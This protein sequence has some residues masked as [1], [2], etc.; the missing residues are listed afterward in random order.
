MINDYTFSNE[1]KKFLKLHP[2]AAKYLG[3]PYYSPSGEAFYPV[4][5]TDFFMRYFISTSR[6]IFDIVE[7]QFKKF[8]ITDRVTL[9]ST[10]TNAPKIVH[11]GDLY[12]DTFYRFHMGSSEDKNNR[13]STDKMTHH[14]LDHKPT[15]SRVL[16]EGVLF[17][18]IKYPA[19]SVFF[20][21]FVTRDH[22]RLFVSEDGAIY[23]VTKNKFRQILLNEHGMPYIKS[24][25][26]VQLPIPVAIAFTWFDKEL[27]YNEYKC[28]TTS[29]AMIF[30][31]VN[32]IIFSKPKMPQVPIES[33]LIIQRIHG[34]DPIDISKLSPEFLKSPHSRGAMESIVGKLYRIPIVGLVSNYY[35]TK[36]GIIYSSNSNKVVF[37]TNLKYDGRDVID[38]L[39]YFP[40][41]E[42]TLSISELILW[43]FFRLCP[44]DISR[45]E[46]T[47][48][49]DMIPIINELWI[50]SK[51]P[52]QI[53]AYCII[54]DEAYREND[55]LYKVYFSKTGAMYN[56]KYRKFID[57]STFVYADNMLRLPV[58]KQGHESLLSISILMYK[59]WFTKAFPS[60]LI[61]S[62][63][64]G[65]LED[66]SLHNLTVNILT[67]AEIGA[68]YISKLPKIEQ[69]LQEAKARELRVIKREYGTDDLE[70]LGSMYPLSQFTKF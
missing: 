25:C 49:R 70:L 32:N 68:R 3:K 61:T 18:E 11:V 51:T 14:Y 43:T 56:A 20:R 52:P 27:N 21:H 44:K 48:N 28:T 59:S 50:T 64:N 6:T 33:K 34:G 22:R 54:S 38:A 66:M 10:T 58:I 40:E 13:K 47:I 9:I 26:G 12:W 39:Y 31:N 45:F 1:A 67:P 19:D 42:R 41:I 5:D 23:D 4:R 8:A 53:D 62:F 60:G 55:I 2:I 7:N 36:C 17:K 30:C 69:R 37:P 46:I 29:E 63:R 24:K 16:I 65:I 35:I 57:Y 15:E